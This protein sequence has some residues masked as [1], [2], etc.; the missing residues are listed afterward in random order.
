MASVD[1]RKRENFILSRRRG[2][3]RFEDSDLGW[4][5]GRFYMTSFVS[6]IADIVSFMS[7]TKR[8][9]IF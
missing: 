2:D 3:T 9:T 7:N 5:E 1:V 6:E 8:V 4:R